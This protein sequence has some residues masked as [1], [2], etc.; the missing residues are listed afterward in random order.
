MQAI[1][2]IASLERYKAENGLLP[3][4]LDELVPKYMNAL[5]KVSRVLRY[6][7]NTQSLGYTYTPSWPQP[8]QISCST[9]IGSNEW[10]CH[11]Y[12]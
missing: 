12:I 10:S 4:S 8:G 2:I 5:P 7:S 3:S 6:S 11:G 1:A 9:V